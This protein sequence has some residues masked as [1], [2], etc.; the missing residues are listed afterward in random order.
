MRLSEEIPLTGQKLASIL[1]LVDINVARQRLID[2]S[3]RAV[4]ELLRVLS[5]P[6]T[7][8]KIKLQACEAILD[9]AG[10]GRQKIVT[11]QVINIS[12]TGS[13][14]DLRKQREAVLQEIESVSKEL[15]ACKRAMIS[16]P[17]P[18]STATGQPTTA[19]GS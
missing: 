18:T 8:P 19:T 12:A 4:E 15:E 1:G 17:K 2:A 9:R 14:E 6:R 13:L 3:E 7:S 11:G 10:L 5:D 16:A